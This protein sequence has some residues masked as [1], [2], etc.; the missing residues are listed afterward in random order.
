MLGGDLM[1]TIGSNIKKRREELG[2]TQEELAKKL[3]YKSKSTINKIEMGINDINQTKI[4]TF[5]NVLEVPP[6]FLMGWENET[7]T[8]CVNKENNMHTKVIDLSAVLQNNTS[9]LL[10]YISNII[11]NKRIKMDLT[12]NVIANRSGI[13]LQEYLSLEVKNENIGNDKIINVIHT[14]DIDFYYFIGHLSGFQYALNAVDDMDISEDN[15]AALKETLTR[16]IF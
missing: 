7:E 2:L 11:K 10:K 16:K 15:K 6:S 8:L 1:S 9:Y 5:A 14:L 13:S 4:I 12:E 3:G